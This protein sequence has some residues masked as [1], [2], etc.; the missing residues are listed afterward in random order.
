MA[1]HSS[2]MLTYN[3]WD[4]TVSHPEDCDEDY[5]VHLKKKKS[6]TSEQKWGAFI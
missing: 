5:N 2:K 3:L 1:V 4:Y 6:E